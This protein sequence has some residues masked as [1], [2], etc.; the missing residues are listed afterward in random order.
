MILNTNLSNLTVITLAAGK[1]TRMRSALP[2]VFHPI[3]GLP[4]VGHVLNTAATLNPK[5]K[6]IVVSPDM[7]AYHDMLTQYGAD[8]AV[9]PHALGTANAVQAALEIAPKDHGH[10]DITLI[11]YGDTP[12]ITA[13]TLE[14]LLNLKADLAILAFE[15]ANPQGYGRIIADQHHHVSR[16]IEQK[17]TSAMEATIHLC[18]SGVIA[19]R[20]NLLPELLTHISN[21]N[22]ANEYYLTDIVAAASKEGY[23]CLYTSCEEEEL[24]GIND[25][26]QLAQAEKIYQKRKKQEVMLEGVTL[27]DPEHIYLSYDT[28]LAADVTIYPHVYFDT[29]VIVETGTVIHSFSHLKGVTIG[30]SCQIGPF[31][32]LRP[33]TQIEEDVKIGNFVEVK[34]STIRKGS[35]INH[36]SYIGDSLLEK[37]VNIGAGTITCNYDGFEKHKTYIGENVFIGS[38]SALV[39]PLHIG[40]DVIIG[41]GS[42]ITRDVDEDALALSRNEQTSIVGG[43]KR[44][45]ARNYKKP[46]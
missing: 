15:A 27:I 43:A 35:K 41:A 46:S 23:T 7:A 31:A 14:N 19:I 33:N 25:R 39:A 28:K 36:L 37:N 5:Q 30:K 26:V 10:N 1:G 6:I 18:N 45:R 44:F 21:Q 38:N 16:I 13:T 4:M 32:R 34:K 3:A 22:A 40:K 9:Q 12:L 17:D 8:I 2:K 11:L 29:G 20:S 24:I 42:T